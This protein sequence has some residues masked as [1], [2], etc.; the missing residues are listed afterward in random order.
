MEQSNKRTVLI[1]G[2]TGGL[3]TAMCKELY[4]DG[5]KVVGNYHT[6]EKAEKWMEQMKSEGFPIEML[7]ILKVPV[8]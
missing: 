5:Y 7:V 3:G 8:K 6:K 2:A 4:K 1:T